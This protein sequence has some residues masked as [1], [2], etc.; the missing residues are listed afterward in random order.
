MP[1]LFRSESTPDDSK[2]VIRSN[3]TPDDDITEPELSDDTESDWELEHLPLGEALPTQSEKKLSFHEVLEQQNLEE[4]ECYTQHDAKE[5][6]LFS[7]MKHISENGDEAFDMTRSQTDFEGITTG[8]K[9]LTFEI[10]NLPEELVNMLPEEWRERKFISLFLKPQ[11]EAIKFKGNY[12]DSVGGDIQV[13]S[14]PLR[15]RLARF[16]T[17][18]LFD[19]HDLVPETVLVPY[20]GKL[21]SVML[22]IENME[23][24]YDLRD[25][26]QKLTAMEN[27]Y[28]NFFR[29][30]YDSVHE[31]LQEDMQWN[32]ILKLL[33]LECDE[34]VH[35]KN[36][37]FLR[38]NGAL[39]Q[40]RLIDLDMTFSLPDDFLI[41]TK[42]GRTPQ[43]FSPRA[44]SSEPLLPQVR[45]KLESLKHDIELV[46]N[47][48]GDERLQKIAAMTDALVSKI[49]LHFHLFSWMEY[50]IEIML[51]E[52]CIVD[53]DEL[54]LHAEQKKKENPA[55]L[56][57][58]LSDARM[59][60]YLAERERMEGDGFYAPPSDID[61]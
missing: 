2:K 21:Y 45:T 47:R 19:Q 52:N 40:I 5:A 27:S 54:V 56:D 24:L 36:L 12:Y 18:E 30:V 20:D 9:A 6:F 16:F 48:Q 34:N 41:I 51:Q 38:N 15:S 35:G 25:Q 43:P 29:E 53:F 8:K 3:Q 55:A 44:L 13:S 7:L 17:S 1:E 60:W 26:H 46:R 59:R 39:D 23:R 57:Q 33:L 4:W 50:V 61:A 22:F 42:D 28:E 10:A 32:A 58:V 11:Q 49:G 31:D 37:G 14:F